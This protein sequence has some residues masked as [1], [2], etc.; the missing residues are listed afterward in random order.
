[1]TMRTTLTLLTVALLTAAPRPALAAEGVDA[2]LAEAAGDIVSFLKGRDAKTVAVGLIR[3]TADDKISHGPGLGLRLAE[4]LVA[5]GLTIDKAADYAVVGEYVDKRDPKS[6]RAFIQLE[7]A[8]TDAKKGTKLLPLGRRIFGEDA[9]LELLAPAALAIPPETLDDKRE[10]LIVKGIDE[11]RTKPQWV[12][13]GTA[14]YA[15]ADKLYGVEFLVKGPDGK[16]AGRAPRAADGDL[17]IDLKKGESFRIRLLNRSK[18]EAGAKVTMDGISTFSF[19]AFAKT[20]QKPRWIVAAGKAGT[21]TGWPTG[22]GKSREFVVTDYAGSAAAELGGAGAKL[23]VLTVE[24]AA[25][26]PKD[27]AAPA[28]EPDLRGAKGATGIGRGAEFD[29]PVTRLER[30][31]GRTRAVISLRYNKD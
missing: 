22:D 19:G 4:K 24:F 30:T 9:L 31:Y 23:G 5:G 6:G 8:V 10:A 14:V 18:Y 25:A 17:L 7:L 16:Y 27:G 2:E 3:S 1:M 21:V 29:T 20:E 12:I 15:G 11:L 13:D 26:W 28:D